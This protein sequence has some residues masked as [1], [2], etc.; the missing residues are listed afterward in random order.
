V[1][2][3]RRRLRRRWGA[4]GG[5]VLCEKRNNRPGL[6]RPLMARAGGIR[7]EG[8]GGSDTSVLRGSKWR[9]AGGSDRRGTLT[10][11]GP[12]RPRVGKRK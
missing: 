7:G 5:A 4:R 1:R 9:E 2:W 10:S 12:G 3:N 8:N 6:R 11:R